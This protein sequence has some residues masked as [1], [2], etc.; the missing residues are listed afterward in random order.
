[1]KL[2]TYNKKRNFSA[3]S[4]PQGRPQA[5][6]AGGIFVIQHHFARR[7]HYDFRLEHNG[8]LL[9][10]AVPKG[11]SNNPNDKRLAVQ[12][13]DHPLEY[14]KFEGVIPAGNYGA[15][16]VEIFDFG[17]FTPSYDLDFGIKKGHIKIKLNGKKF[18]G[19]YSLIKMKNAG[20]KN[21][22]KNKEN[23][24]INVEKINKTENKKFKNT[25]ENNLWFIKCESAQKIK[26]KEIKNSNKNPFKNCSVQL[27][28]LTNKIPTGKDWVFEI[29]YDGYRV[30]TYKEDENVKCLTR[31]NKDYTKRFPSI[32][33][34]IKKLKF[35]CILD[36]EVVAFD[37]LGKSDF[38]LLQEKLKTAPNELEYVVF[39]LLALNGKDLRTIPLIKRKEMLKNI[40]IKS[41]KN[42]I[43]SEHII[44]KGK[45]CF[46]FAKKNNLEGI[47]AKNINSVY[48][49]KRNE[50][51][52]KIKCY[53]RQEFVIIGF[54][55]TEKNPLL[56]AILVG[57]YKNKKLYYV[58]KVGTGFNEKLKKE[59]NNKLNKIKSDCKVDFLPNKKIKAN[60]VKPKYV[61]EIKF[62]ELTKDS[63][64]RQPSFVGLREDKDAKTINLEI[65]K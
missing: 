49:G 3:T 40:L 19:E 64:L 1:M 21:E 51:W 60:W 53:M 56:S 38:S 32:V 27:C 37:N 22:N 18:N 36:G 62:A 45:Q 33:E 43:F 24:K 46:N 28:T 16:S 30:V 63:I 48:A 50:D 61:A 5:K 58:G 9:S 20:N 4:E 12:V 41:S 26:N 42:L 29:K 8:V 52:L 54:L 14:A 7:E 47:V 10:W 44:G 2:T 23:K 11:L 6:S 59:L 65:G 15:G 17:T 13:E 39:D 55:T 35:N 57:Y 25:K 31:N 34:G